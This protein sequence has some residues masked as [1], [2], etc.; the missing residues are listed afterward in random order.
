M[1]TAAPVGGCGRLAEGHPAFGR[2]RNALR[3][4]LPQ[5]PWK[6]ARQPWRVADRFPTAAWKTA[7]R[8]WRVAD[9]FPTVPTAPGDYYFDSENY[10]DILQTPTGPGIIHRRVLP[11]VPV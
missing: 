2:S 4:T 5:P 3:A 7:R 11:M 9:R 8:P 6:T 10:R 1:E